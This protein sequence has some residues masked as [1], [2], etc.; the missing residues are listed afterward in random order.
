M[1]VNQ[2]LTTAADAYIGIDVPRFS[3]DGQYLITSLDETTH[4][5]WQLDNGLD[6]LLAR[7]CNLLANHFRANPSQREELDICL[8]HPL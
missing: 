8:E 7:G 1:S 4:Q 3:D 2:R 5:I 6:D